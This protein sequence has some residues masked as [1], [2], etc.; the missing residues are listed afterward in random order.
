MDG[1]TWLA[2]R[3]PRPEPRANTSHNVVTPTPS[4]SPLSFLFPRKVASP[5]VAPE[6]PGWWED[7]GEGAP[8][9][10]DFFLGSSAWQ[11]DPRT[12]ALK[13]D[14]AKGLLGSAHR[15]YTRLLLNSAVQELQKRRG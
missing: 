10:V 11:T 4:S 14:F 3:L 12:G 2:V 7:I 13:K 6:V 15:W 8:A 5:V 9:H 1:N